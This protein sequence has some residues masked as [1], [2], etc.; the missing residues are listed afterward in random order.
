[1]EHKSRRDVVLEALR[2][3]GVPDVLGDEVVTVLA[4]AGYDALAPGR[5]SQRDR[6]E[7]IA[8]VEGIVSDL[9]HRMRLLQSD[10]DVRARQDGYGYARLAAK[11]H[12]RLRVTD[13]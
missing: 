2:D 13:V 3:A 12:S 9:L 6:F 8:P 1:M 5:V 10:P 11:L 7:E 4:D